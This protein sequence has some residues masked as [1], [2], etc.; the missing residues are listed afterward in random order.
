MEGKDE[1]LQIDWKRPI[2]VRTLCFHDNW[3]TILEALRKVIEE[4]CLLNLFYTDKVS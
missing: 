3:C 2:V 4:A 1:F